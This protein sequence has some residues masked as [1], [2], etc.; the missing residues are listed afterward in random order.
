MCQIFDRMTLLTQDCRDK[1]EHVIF[2][3]GARFKP[4]APV[5]E[6]F[7]NCKPVASRSLRVKC[8]LVAI[9]PSVLSVVDKDN[10][11][12]RSHVRVY[13][14]PQISSPVWPERKLAHG[15][16]LSNRMESQ[17]G[18][19]L[20]LLHRLQ[21]VF[22]LN[23]HSFLHMAHRPYQTSIKFYTEPSGKEGRQIA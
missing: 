8:I 15:G 22:C 21:Q 17:H 14:G 5:F 6:R 11:C 23:H 13:V 12:C 2:M 20:R 16:Y 1:H 3:A 7:K 18:F 4:I 10:S 19:I 9:E